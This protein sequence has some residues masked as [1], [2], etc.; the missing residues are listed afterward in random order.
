VLDELLAAV[1]RWHSRAGRHARRGPVDRGDDRTPLASQGPTLWLDTRSLEDGDD[2]G[3]DVLAGHR[4]RWLRDH[5]PCVT[6]PET[7]PQGSSR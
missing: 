1:D 5:G 3:W 7:I 6:W 4:E 2:L